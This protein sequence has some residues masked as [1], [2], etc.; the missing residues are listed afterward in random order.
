MFRFLYRAYFSLSLTLSHNF[1]SY[2]VRFFYRLCRIHSGFKCKLLS[3]F[4]TL[5]RQW[6]WNFYLLQNFLPSEKS[7][8]CDHEEPKNK[9]QMSSGIESKKS[10][11]SSFARENCRAR[12]LCWKQRKYLLLL[13]RVILTLNNSMIAE[14][15][16]DNRRLQHRRL[17][18]FSLLTCP[19]L[20]FEST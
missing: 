4:F 2:L 8:S 9:M 1:N 12:F 3:S 18:L 17:L 10:H 15:H 16:D 6:S 19:A 20:I 13:I 14:N 5:W 7:N 11:T